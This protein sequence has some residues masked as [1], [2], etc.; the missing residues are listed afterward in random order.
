MSIILKIEAPLPAAG[1]QEA[2]AQR[3]AGKQFRGDASYM[4][5]GV[6]NLLIGVSLRS[7][8]L[9]LFGPLFRGI[10]DLNLKHRKTPLEVFRCCQGLIPGSEDSLGM[11]IHN[12]RITTCWKFFVSGS[13]RRR[14]H[15]LLALLAHRNTPFLVHE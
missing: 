1:G 7:G 3:V 2:R 4:A 6:C 12:E 9:D 5:C 10:I 13:G 14:S 8:Q 11:T 15:S